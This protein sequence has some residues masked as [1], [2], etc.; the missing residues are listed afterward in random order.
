[1][2][3]TIYSLV[4]FCTL[5]A[6]CSGSS[7][8][9]PNSDFSFSDLRLN[10]ESINQVGVYRKTSL[11]LGRKQSS[12]VT[13][14]QNDSYLVGYNT[15]GEAT[16][17]IYLNG[18]NQEVEVPLKVFS[19][20][21]I[22]D[23]AYI[24]YY[25][26]QI[27]NDLNHAAYERYKTSIGET[28]FEKVLKQLGPH[29]KGEVWFITLHIPSG[30]LFNLSEAFMLDSKIGNNGNFLHFS[31]HEKKLTYFVK[32]FYENNSVCKGDLVFD[33]ENI[34]LS[35]TETC[36]NLDIKPIFAD[37]MG[38][39]VYSFNG[40]MYYA[41]SDFTIVGELTEYLGLAVYEQNKFIKSV[42]DDIVLLSPLKNAF[43]VFNS[44]FELKSLNTLQNFVQI[45]PLINIDTRWLYQ[46]DA[47]DYLA[48]FSGN[49]FWVVD[50][51]NFIANE[52]YLD[53][54]SNLPTYYVVFEDRAYVISGNIFVWE[55]ETSFLK[56]EENIYEIELSFTN[57]YTSGYLNYYQFQGLTKIKKSLNLQS[58]RVYLENE[59]KPIITVTQVQ[60]I[61]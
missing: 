38:Y 27:I 7:E 42:G 56:I 33:E 20:E 8:S 34:N 40:K 32:R 29:V 36:T 47:K 28:T 17:L 16:P 55:S 60:P 48:Y 10:L 30:K 50:F 57:L 24:I 1:M 49:M 14:T 59:E 54:S 53:N 6:G 21:V 2:K 9:I 61:N 15:Q 12:V 44:S 3:K 35:K 13:N 51:E 11:P 39:F 23:F 25:D 26:S 5:I 45:S 19:F 46:V 31:P 4:V 18:E 41:S 43:V 22:G 52:I 58:G 37:D